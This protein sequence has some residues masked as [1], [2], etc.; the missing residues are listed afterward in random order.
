MREKRN[1]AHEDKVV[2]SLNLGED[3]LQN[4]LGSCR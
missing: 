1:V 4:L 3:A 2:I